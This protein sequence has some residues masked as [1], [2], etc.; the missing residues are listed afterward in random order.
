[1]G[2][3]KFLKGFE[4]IGFDGDVFSHRRC[5]S[6]AGGDIEFVHFLALRDFPCKG[7]LA[8]SAA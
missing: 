5:A 2:G 3:G 7:M 8:P 6:V 4:V 1:M